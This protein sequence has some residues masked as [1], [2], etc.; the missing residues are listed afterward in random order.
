M[1][2]DRYAAVDLFALVSVRI[3]AESYA[4]TAEAM[5]LVPLLGSD[6]DLPGAIV[7]EPTATSR[8]GMATTS[9]QC[10]QG[11]PGPGRRQN[12]PHSSHCC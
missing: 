9:S 2:R 5:S 10:G 3:T 4:Q 6:Q 8:S 7:V 11:P 12:T 1:L